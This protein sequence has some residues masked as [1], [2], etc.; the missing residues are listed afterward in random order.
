VHLIWYWLIRNAED[1]KEVA[2]A[3]TQLWMPPKGVEPDRG[4]WSAESEM[5]A[6]RSL[7]R[8]LEQ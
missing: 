8:A 6:F 5:E 4:P 3:K 2:K 1:P 7:Q